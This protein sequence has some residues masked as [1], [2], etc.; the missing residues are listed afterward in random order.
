MGR[1]S[2]EN[3]ATAGPRDRAAHENR[4]LQLIQTD[5]QLALLRLL[6]AD[7]SK[8]RLFTQEDWDAADESGREIFNARREAAEALEERG[9]VWHDIWEWAL[10]ARGAR[11]VGQLPQSLPALTLH[12]ALSLISDHSLPS[13]GAIPHA[14]HGY[15]DPSWLQVENAH[16]SGYEAGVDA[17]LRFAREVLARVAS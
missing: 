6:P 9:L 16:E 4:D 14:D 15:E 5:D 12:E 2:A 1:G 3:E 13:F 17:G 11:L 7:R 10:T 8:A